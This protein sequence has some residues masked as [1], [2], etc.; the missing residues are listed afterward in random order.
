M[1]RILK[2]QM[3]DASQEFSNPSPQLVH[4]ANQTVPQGRGEVLPDPLVIRSHP[5]A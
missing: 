3:P 1:L 4:L 2:L 5:E